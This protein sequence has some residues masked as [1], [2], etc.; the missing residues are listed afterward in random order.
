MTGTLQDDEIN[1]IISRILDAI[2]KK[3]RAYLR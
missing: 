1:S 2:E 3:H